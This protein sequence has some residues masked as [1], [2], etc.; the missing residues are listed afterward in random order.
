M[1]MPRSL[2]IHPVL[3][4]LAGALCAQ[5]T[6]GQEGASA[7]DQVLNSIRELGN[8][9]AG[10]ARRIGQWVKDKV[11][12]LEKSDAED[13]ISR[14]VKSFEAQRLN[15]AN[16]A[17]FVDA[18]AEQT[19]GVALE[20]F[21]KK[22]LNWQVGMALGR[23]LV[24]MD[25]VQTIPAFV[26]GIASDAEPV[27][28][29]SAK[30]LV[31]QQDAI[32]A[33]KNQRNQVVAAVKTAGQAETKG[34]ILQYLYSAIAYRPLTQEVFD[35]YLA[36]LDARLA[37]RRAGALK[38]DGAEV[39]LYEYFRAGGMPESLSSAQKTALVQRLAV[40]LRMD[41]QRYATPNLDFVEQDHLERCLEG[42]EDIL[43]RSVGPG[44]DIAQQLSN[45]AGPPAVLQQVHQW[46]GDQATGVTGKL[47]GPPW[48]IE[49]GA[50]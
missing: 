9:G 20:W 26:A 43:A 18:L 46:V 50:P 27:R 6:L 29:L 15:R 4:F 40:M 48:N 17:A 3:L 47:N 41:A 31:R 21:A 23:V 45:G 25:R 2:R 38:Y 1:Y 28:Y 14:F 13:R 39:E 19:A 12:A 42:N 16:T 24:N 22:N 5:T 32:A 30:G 49:P 11:T 37:R 7:G 36:I 10:D 34:V 8:V 44:G 33:N 35:A